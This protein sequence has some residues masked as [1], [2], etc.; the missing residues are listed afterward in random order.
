MTLFETLKLI[1]VLAAIV[2]L[3]G[4][5]ITQF[6]AVRMKAAEP[7]HRLGFARDL[8]FVGQRVYAPA[9]LVALGTGLWMVL[10]R[11]A[12]QFTQA[13]IVIGLGGLVVTILLAVGLV[14][15]RTKQ[16]IGLIEAGNGPAAGPIIAQVTRG[17][18]VAVLILALATWAMTFK[19]GLDT[20]NGVLFPT[21]LLVHVLAVMAWFGGGILS[22]VFIA[23]MRKA[24]A[25]HR[26]GFARDEE[27]V[28]AVYGIA[29]GLA[30]I[31]GVWMVLDRPDYS[32]GQAW[33]IIGITG[34]VLSSIV[35]G[36]RL[37]ASV[38]RLRGA[39]ESG[40]DGVGLLRRV[41]RTAMLDETIL[42]VVVWAMVF[43]PGI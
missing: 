41:G 23:R 27:K 30:A 20:G 7:Q 19:P 18:R 15:P 10:D 38:K 14:I 16:A 32:F 35:G 8:V 22:T 40:G 36:A 43:R 2:W 28:S 17:G 31:A 6:F 5:I 11:D 13:W 4:G 33:V 34:F 12:Y 1:H 21:L 26:L 42:L 24:D 39:L 9:A 3:G 25:A 29:S 37:G